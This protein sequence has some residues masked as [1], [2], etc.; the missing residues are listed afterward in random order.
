MTKKNKVNE[1]EAKKAGRPAATLTMEQV[2]ELRALAA[3]LTQEQI[4]DYF[5]IAERTLHN[6]FDR[7]PDIYA[8]YKQG[9]VRAIARS[10]QTLTKIAWGYKD[11]MTG[12]NGEIIKDDNGQAVEI[13]NKPDKAALMFHL[14][15]KGG[16]RETA[17]LEVTGKDGKDLAPTINWSKLST[18]TIKSVLEAQ[19][20]DDDEHQAEQRGFH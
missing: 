3:Y 10:A 16:W 2:S 17:N 11:I 4:A 18:E 1:L 15:T 20:I 12:A 19:A 14:K 7:E 6:I 9:A 5:G 8:A 13:Y